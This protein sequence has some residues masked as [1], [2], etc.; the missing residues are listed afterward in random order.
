MAK[1]RRTTTRR[2]G[3]RPMT[4][5]QRAA[6]RKAQL[7]SAR[8]RRK[9]AARTPRKVGEYHGLAISK[10]TG[11]VGRHSL[12]LYDTKHNRRR[13]RIAGAVGAVAGTAILPGA[14]TVIGY[15]A[16]VAHASKRYGLTTRKQPTR[17]KR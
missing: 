5:R 4:A 3:R 11:R 6:L 10:K 17:R 14:G 2:R 13:R 16:G 9:V 8:K 12:N 15:R 1:A 7:A